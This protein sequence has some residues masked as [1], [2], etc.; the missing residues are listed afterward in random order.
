MD[1]KDND[2]HT[3]NPRELVGPW[4]FKERQYLP[5]LTWSQKLN[6]VRVMGSVPFRVVWWTIKYFMP[7]GY[8]PVRYKRRIMNL[9]MAYTLNALSLPELR[10]IL[11]VVPLRRFLESRAL[12]AFAGLPNFNHYFHA[13]DTSARWI[14]EV[15]GRRKEDPVILYLHGGGFFLKTMPEQITWMC[16]LVEA[17]PQHRLSVLE[18]DYTVSPQGQY[19]VQLNEALS[20]YKELTKTCSKIIILGDSAGGNLA[21]SLTA[22]MVK[23]NSP[24]PRPWSVVLVSAWTEFDRVDGSAITNK[25][26][27]YL[28]LDNN[29][30]LTMYYAG[31]RDNLKNPYVNMWVGGS[32]FWQGVFPERTIAVWGDKELFRDGCRRFAKMADIKHTFEEPNGVHDVLMVGFRAPSSK[33]ITQT[34]DKWLSEPDRVAP[35]ATSS[36]VSSSRL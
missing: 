11:P 1:S 14:T 10:L 36:S 4:D 17:L 21:S 5:A 28:N 30:T 34:L 31:T 35:K 29:D 9:V 27:D 15:N 22:H 32:E 3:V 7:G 25:D 19:P 16:K 6:F 33:F 20:V 24:L 8:R 2:I 18:L 26:Y 23:N 12:R 13:D